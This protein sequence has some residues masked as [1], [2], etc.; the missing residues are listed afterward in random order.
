[1]EVATQ[2]LTRRCLTPV[3][4]SHGADWAAQLP[5]PDGQRSC[6]CVCVGGGGGGGGGGAHSN[7]H[8]TNMDV[9][10]DHTHV[11]EQLRL[12]RV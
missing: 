2:P 7:A 11:D 8:F 3:G 9:R 12:Q 6:V 1:M 4:N 10:C 5:G